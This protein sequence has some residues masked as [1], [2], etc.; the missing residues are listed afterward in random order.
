MT[1]PNTIIIKKVSQPVSMT[2]IPGALMRPSASMI[3]AVVKYAAS[4]ITTMGNTTVI[5]PYSLSARSSG[6]S[7][8]SHHNNPL[9]SRAAIIEDGPHDSSSLSS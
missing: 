5:K 3:N 4:N 9:P 8:T 2:L 1:P 7:K 6:P